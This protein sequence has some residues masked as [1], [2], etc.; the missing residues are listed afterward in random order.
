[1]RKWW[2]GDINDRDG[3]GEVLGTGMVRFCQGE[4]LGTG[5]VRFCQEV[6]WDKDSQ[7]LSGIVM[8]FT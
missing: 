4:V 5:I 2:R 7:V 3:Q 8:W 1:M 6:C